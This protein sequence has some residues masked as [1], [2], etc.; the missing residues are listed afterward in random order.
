MAAELAPDSFV[1]ADDQSLPLSDLAERP[2]VEAAL[3]LDMVDSRGPE[4]SLDLPVHGAGS[5]GVTGA[6]GAIDRLTHE[7]LASLEQRPTLVV[8]LFDES[9]SFRD[10]R[11]AIIKRFRR[12]YDELGVIEASGN[13][14]FKQ[15]QDKPLLS[16][17]VEFGQNI[18]FLTPKPTDDVEEIKA[19]VAAIKTDETGIERVFQAVGQTIDRY[20]VFRTQEPRRNVMLVVFT[21]EVG[22]DETE[23]DRTVTLARNLEIPVYCVGVPAPFGRREASIKYVDPDENIV[24]N[25]HAFTQKRVARHFTPL[26]YPDSF[27]DLDECSNP[28]L[29]AD[30]TSVGVDERIDLDALAECYIVETNEVISQVL[31]GKI[32]HSH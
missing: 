29:I 7:I 31:V 20:R 2:A 10:E 19:A 15:H 6:E 13:P 26:A 21:D 24:L 14:A 4:V 12:I 32:G 22:D 5:V 18:T 11:K 1:P 8:W 17:V 27:L 23:L 3:D 28:A 16:S 25:S 9:G 30:L